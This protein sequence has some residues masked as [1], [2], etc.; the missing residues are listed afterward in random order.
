MVRIVYASAHLGE[1]AKCLEYHN[2][3]APKIEGEGFKRDLAKAKI[4]CQN[5]VEEGKSEESEN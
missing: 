4:E 2:L 3:F 1:K 5:I